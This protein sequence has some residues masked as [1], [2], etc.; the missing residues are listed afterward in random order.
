MIPEI[1]L[2]DPEV[3]RDP[4]SAH[5]RAR[6]LSPVARLVGPGFPG[7]WV[8]TRYADARAM[9]A[10]PRFGPSA[11]TFPRLPVPE[12][13]QP[14]L[15]T[16]QE[17]EG[18]E[19]SRLRRRV[20]PSFSA[21]R[22]AEFRPRIEPIVARLLDDLAAEPG[23]VD[24]LDRFARP[25]PM[26]VI[27]ELV[28]IAEVDR[29]QW[30]E[31]GGIIFGG[32][33][34]Q[35]I[36]AVPRIIDGT[37]AAVADPVPEDGLIHRLLNP[38]SEQDSLAETEL[39]TLIWTLLLAG[40]TPTNLVANAVE[41]LLT[42]PEQLATLR[43]RPELMPVAVEELTRWCG[44]QLLTL[45]RFTQA[46][47]TIDG[48]TISPGEP[49]IASIAATNRDPRAF[50]DPDRL[51]LTRADDPSRH[52]GYA[53]GPHFCLG[54]PLARVQV[55][56]ALRGLLDRFPDLA[57]AGE[58]LRSPDPGTWRLTTLPVTS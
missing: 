17:M 5:G 16:M 14:Y 3:L 22:A 47:V 56:I 49:V 18:A 28:G 44:P 45:P 7:M 27:C 38:P 1:D 35:L 20:S 6:E 36:E 30:R 39:V 58:P 11:A 37:R 31:W 26:E 54:A 41:A 57:L 21:R 13:C 34:P 24:L 25:L 42:H 43:A 52:L 32:H 40:Q 33:G 23:P 12:H 55:E 50:A 15:R 53:H 46:D 10:D 29:P 8:L 19:H 9:L 51:D 4:F 48:V 2:S